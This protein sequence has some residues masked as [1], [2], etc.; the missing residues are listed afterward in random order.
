M[1]CIIWHKQGGEEMQ[2]IVPYEKTPV[3]TH[4]HSP[5]G[6]TFDAAITKSLQPLVYALIFCSKYT[7]YA[8]NLKCYIFQH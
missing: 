2:P 3:L 1:C 4:S 8:N 7:L 5:D 6:N